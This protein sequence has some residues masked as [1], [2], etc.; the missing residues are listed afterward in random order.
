M[1]K[2]TMDKATFILLLT[3]WNLVSSYIVSYFNLP[4][5]EILLIAG[6]GSAIIAWLRDETGFTDVT[7]P[8]E[9]T[10]IQQTAQT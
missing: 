8:T 10:Q 5:G 6:L 4:I 9:T 7:V 2:I 1:Q 3:I